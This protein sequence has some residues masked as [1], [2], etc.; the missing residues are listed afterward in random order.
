MIKVPVFIEGVTLPWEGLTA[1]RIAALSRKAAA[2]AGLDEV[3]FSVILTDNGRMQEINSVYR[4][5]N[6]PTDVISFANRDT[7]FPRPVS[8]REEL[9]DLFISL[10]QARLQAAD[11][12]VAGIDEF[13]RLLV[14]G[15]LHLAGYDHEEGPAR[16]REMA[17]R[18]EAILALL[19]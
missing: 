7:A 18:E 6:R 5:K 11:Y 17:A 1:R 10:D 12:G 19:R 13:K 9:G 14:H 4:G 2:A 16:A 3:S 8:G 15:I